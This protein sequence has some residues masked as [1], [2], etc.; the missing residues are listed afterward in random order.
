MSNARAIPK[1]P[2]G[3]LK[4][5]GAIGANIAPAGTVALT[6]KYQRVIFAFIVDT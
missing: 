3:R 4:R 6:G 5:H 2:M 1:P